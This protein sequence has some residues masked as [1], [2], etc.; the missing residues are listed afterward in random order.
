MPAT[1]TPKKKKRRGGGRISQLIENYRMTRRSDPTVGW[2]ML[3]AF[4]GVLAVTVALVTLVLN[5]IS[6]LILGIPLALLAA[7]Y[8]FSRKAI[9]AAYK[10]IEGQPGAAAAVIESMRGNWSVTSAVA[11]TKNQDIVHRVVGKPGVILI[12]EGTPTRLTNLLANERRR[13][14]RFVAEVPIHE[15]QVGEIEGQVPLMKLQKALTKLPAT[16]RPA[17][18]TEIRRRL[19]A[20]ASSPVPVPKGPLPKNARMP[21]APR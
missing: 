6:G 4:V 11:V 21:R 16:L 14:A 17:E 9:R 15:L 3:G 5:W 7:T 18:V 1:P 8:I 10:Q 13:T 20:L 19:D 2:V 12:G